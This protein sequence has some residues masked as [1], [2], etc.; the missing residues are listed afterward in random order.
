MSPPSGEPARHDTKRVLLSWSSGK[1]SAWTLHCLRMSPGVE[2]VGLLAS[3]NKAA[4]RVAMHAVRR[5]LVKAQADAAGLPLTA[6]DLPW[7]CSNADY[8]ARMK[9]A[10]DRTREDGVT[11]VAFGDLF[12]EDVRAYRE[13][14]LEG[15]GLAPLF[16]IWGRAT[17]ALAREMVAG[18]LRAILT[19]VDPRQ[20]AA[21]FVGRDFDD[22]FL[23]A[24]PGA[25]DPCSERGEFHSFAFAG[26]M[27]HHPIPVRRG[28]QVVRDGFPFIDLLAEGVAVDA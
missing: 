2:V 16:P 3:F 9:A 18:G 28:E 15:T 8:E 7:P 22:T 19:C 13:R 17:P 6:I 11:H 23:D 10:L 25:V 14:M 27:F 4:D 24:L 1:D 12:L 26:P 20:L 21:E 5:A